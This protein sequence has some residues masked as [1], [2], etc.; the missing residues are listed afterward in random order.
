MPQTERLKMILQGSQYNSINDIAFADERRMAVRSLM[1]RVQLDTIADLPCLANGIKVRP[2]DKTA[3]WN[4]CGILWFNRD[5]LKVRENQAN[6]P[7]LCLDRNGNWLLFI[8][9]ILIDELGEHATGLTSVA[10]SGFER[11]CEI[12][13]ITGWEVTSKITSKLTAWIEARKTQLAEME[14][15]ALEFFVED[16]A[17]KALTTS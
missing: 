3:P 2:G 9:S 17:I 5:A 13:C 6:L 4:I 15:I 8:L 10:D 14:G 11:M 12:A 7:I 1:R 16:S